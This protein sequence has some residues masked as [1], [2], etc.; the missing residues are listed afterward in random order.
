MSVREIR[1]KSAGCEN[2]D[3]PGDAGKNTQDAFVTLGMVNRGRKKVADGPLGTQSM[4]TIPPVNGTSANEK[5]STTGAT[6]RTATS[7]SSMGIEIL[8]MSG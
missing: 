8:T 7:T 3:K 4:L 5:P 2:G 6:S 1:A